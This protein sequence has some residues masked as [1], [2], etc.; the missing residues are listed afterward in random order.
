MEM[1]EHEV[2]PDNVEK[3][4][5]MWELAVRDGIEQEYIDLDKQVLE[6]LEAGVWHIKQK[7]LTS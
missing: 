1:G 4:E 3:Y 2:K 5:D 7:N 6:V